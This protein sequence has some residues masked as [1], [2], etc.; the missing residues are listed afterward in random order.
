M[1]KILNKRDQQILQLVE[2]LEQN[3]TYTLLSLEEQLKINTRTLYNL[4]EEFNIKFS[5][6]KIH[7]DASG[8]IVIF[9]QKNFSIKFIY[10]KILANS[11]E[12]NILEALFFEN[13]LTI[14]TLAED[15][16]LSTSTLRRI[17]K[18]MN[19]IL[20]TEGFHIRYS[21][22]SI[23]GDEQKICNFIIYYII[24]KY[25]D[26]TNFFKNRQIN[27]AYQ[28]LETTI[29]LKNIELTYSDK[30][31]VV[32]WVLT[33]L[34]RSK[35]NK[36]S[37]KEKNFPDEK[38]LFIYMKTFFKID[39]KNNKYIRFL[40]TIFQKKLTLSYQSILKKSKNNSLSKSKL[41]AIEDLLS[42]TCELFNIPLPHNSE[43]LIEKLYFITEIQYGKPYILFNED[44]IFYERIS[45]YFSPKFTLLYQIIYDSYMK[46]GIY[47]QD[48]QILSYLYNLTINWENFFKH[49]IHSQKK[50]SLALYFP[51]DFEH[52]KLVKYYIDYKLPNM[53][54]I[55]IVSSLQH[56]EKLNLLTITNFTPTNE[57]LD[58]LCI[59]DFP[60]E[61][62]LN[63]LLNFYIDSAQ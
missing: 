49:I 24:E 22:L 28:L 63:W 51:T 32:I 23:V 25:N 59:L 47:L 60:T 33:V 42:S 20:S 4:I 27:F 8:K 37:G 6:M 41:S 35:I 29:R 45:K 11:I 54:D 14:N 44:Y 5:P 17:I 31:K 61:K 9:K 38:N 26:E 15:M 43:S 39:L 48:Y 57:N 10:Q 36:T 12:F 53:F 50:I 1:R 16:Y 30:R 52:A 7:K 34:N 21:P 2:L 3:N 40:N 58:I 46:Y 19:P 56:A 62:D 18:K 13:T 55:N